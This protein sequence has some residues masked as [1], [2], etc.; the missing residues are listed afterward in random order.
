[1][2]AEREALV[3]VHREAMRHVDAEAVRRVL[4]QQHDA[5]LHVYYMYNNLLYI[6]VHDLISSIVGKALAAISQ[7]STVVHSP[8]AEVRRRPHWPRP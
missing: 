6:Y 4:H 7:I 2:V 3:A 8:P 5:Q 1:M